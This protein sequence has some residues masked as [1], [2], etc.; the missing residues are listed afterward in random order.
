MTERQEKLAEQYR[1]L[2]VVCL[3]FVLSVS[4]LVVVAWFVTDGPAAMGALMPG[5][6]TLLGFGG[7]ALGLVLLLVA[8]VVQR[9]LLERSDPPGADG[10]PTPVLENYRIAILLAFVLRE[11][12]ALVGLM[13][14]LV[15]GEAL[16]CYLLSGAAIVAMF[17]GW[18]RQDDL[19]HTPI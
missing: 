5:Q 7:T 9:R 19:V 12:A 16:W 15:T 3:G 4:F 18:P 6:S 8:P 17:W 2:N 13:T 10:D 1:F 14:T 11:G